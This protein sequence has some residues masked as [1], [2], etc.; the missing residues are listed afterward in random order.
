[1]H[2][3]CSGLLSAQLEVRTSASRSQDPVLLEIT[4][5]DPETPD[6]NLHAQNMRNV[7]GIPYAEQ[8]KWPGV[9]VAAKTFFFTW[10]YGGRETQIIKGIE[11]VMGF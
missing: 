7:F 1:M 5:N 9:K 8:H 3:N 10:L 4:N 6:G 11:K 2:S